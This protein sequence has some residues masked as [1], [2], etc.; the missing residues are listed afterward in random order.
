MLISTIT[1]NI[2]FI[3]LSLMHRITE[4]ICKERWQHWCT[5]ISGVKVLPTLL[6]STITSNMSFIQLSLMLSGYP[7]SSFVAGKNPCPKPKRLRASPQL[8]SMLCG[9]MTTRR[10]GNLS[11]P[12]EDASQPCSQG[13]R[14]QV[15]IGFMSFFHICSGS[16]RK[17]SLCIKDLLFKRCLLSLF[18]MRLITIGIVSNHCKVRLV[19]PLKYH[20]A[21][22]LTTVFEGILL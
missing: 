15:S 7:A 20:G 11:G 5:K 8:W 9:K 19:T 16:I 1:S 10:L 21:L 3:Q 13:L 6:I 22:K 2:P 12:P 18:A 17:K 14:N 4:K